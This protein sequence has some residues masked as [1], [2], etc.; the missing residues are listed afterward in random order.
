M[1]QESVTVRLSPEEWRMI[2]TLRDIP[3]GDLKSTLH[4]VLQLAIEL[5]REPSCAE[6]QADGVPCGTAAADCETCAR[7]TGAL[8]SARDRLRSL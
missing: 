5:V 4:E 6:V 3:E 1:E 2:A 7:V 8:E